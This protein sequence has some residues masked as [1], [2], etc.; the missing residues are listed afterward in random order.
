M[1]RCYLRFGEHWPTM[2][3]PKKWHNRH[4]VLWCCLGY[5]NQCTYAIAQSE[6]V[7]WCALYILVPCAVSWPVSLK[8]ESAAK[9]LGMKKHKKFKVLHKTTSSRWSVKSGIRHR[10]RLLIAVGPAS[11]SSFFLEDWPG[12][13][14]WTGWTG[15]NR[16]VLQSNRLS[17]SQLKRWEMSTGR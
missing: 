13:T 17:T 12:W 8:A 4:T 11:C 6:F 9:E 15:Y 3:I 1:N 2:L 14:G 16:M 7:H 5:E 10:W